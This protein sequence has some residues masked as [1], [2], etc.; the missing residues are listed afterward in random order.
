VTKLLFQM[1]YTPNGVAQKDRTAIGFLF[2]K[3]E[4]V[5]R[6]VEVHM[7]I[8]PSFR[9]PAGADN[10]PVESGHRF[11]KDTLILDMTP[12][13]HLRGKAFRYDLK[14]PDGKVETVLNVPR[15]DFNWQV[16][17]HLEKPLFAPAGTELHC[18][19][20]FDNS[21][22][23]LANP[24]FK[25]DVTWG[26]QTWEEMMIGWFTET[27]DVYPEDMPSD[28]TRTAR[29]LASVEKDPP[30]VSKILGRACDVAAKSELGLD[31]FLDRVQKELPQVDRVCITTT[32]GEN[33]QV[34]MA[35]QPYV[36][37]GAIGAEGATYPVANSALGRAIKGTDTVVI[38]DLSKAQGADVA[39]LSRVLSS[40]VQMPITI[41]GKP[42]VISY[43]SKE[44][45]AFPEPALNFLRQIT[46]LVDDAS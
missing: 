30:K 21:E 25:T 24:D 29:F 40:G 36:F 31:R 12:H 22:Y 13:M 17:Y 27:T 10:H 41:G 4:E 19:A 44:K 26:E 11:T 8:N 20:H 18:L 7:A 14:Y 38:S 43:W 32:D 37:D 9:I 28:Q 23:N 34:L 3:P 46:K 15:Y 45:D 33:V 39:A 16:T 35:A 2:S 1:H 6:A 42:A 5:T